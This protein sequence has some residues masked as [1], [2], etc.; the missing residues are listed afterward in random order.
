MPESHSPL[1]SC[2]YTVPSKLDFL[3][4]PTSGHPEGSAQGQPMGTGH[5]T[6]QLNTRW[7]QMADSLDWICGKKSATLS[8]C[9][10]N[11]MAS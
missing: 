3:I 11:Q 8:L 2:L 10:S 7:R 6:L 1:A 5:P 9:N 4:L